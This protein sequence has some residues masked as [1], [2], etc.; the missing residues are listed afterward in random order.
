MPLEHAEEYMV[1]TAMSKGNGGYTF[2]GM[3]TLRGYLSN[4]SLAGFARG[5]KDQQSGETILIPNAFEAA[6]PLD[7]LEP[8]FA[9]ITGEHLD[10]T[11]FVKNGGRRQ[12]RGV[13]SE[14]DAI[15]HGLLTSDEGD[16]NVFANAPEDYPIYNLRTFVGIGRTESVWV[17]SAPIN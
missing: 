9:S 16:V 8:C 7:L 11:L 13:S 15:L 17:L 4:L 5:G 12:Y 10:G 6:V 14:I 2:A 1:R 3:Q